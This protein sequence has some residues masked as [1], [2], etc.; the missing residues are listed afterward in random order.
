MS[1]RAYIREEQNV[2][3]KDGYK[4]ITYKERLIELFNVWHN[5]EIF[6]GE[7]EIDYEQWEELKENEEIFISPKFTEQ[8]YGKEGVE[9]FKKIDS[10][11][12][13]NSYLL[14]NCY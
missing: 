6:V 2:E 10:Y 12:K 4:E 3:Y 9:V 11:L 13:E 1:I 8:K 7:L 14:L 5:P